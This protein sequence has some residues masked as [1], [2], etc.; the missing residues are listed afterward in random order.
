MR[1]YLFAICLF[2]SLSSQLYANNQIDSLKQLLYT[3]KIDTNKVIH[4]NNLCREYENISSHDTALL[5]G[6]TALQL[7]IK[8]K[9]PKGEAISYNNIGTIYF[10]QN[11][12]EKALKNF[13]TSLKIEIADEKGIA[14]TYNNIGLVYEAQAKYDMALE[15]YFTALK[16]QIKIG[17]KRGIASSYS[18]IGIVY[19][20]QTNY[21]MALK[22][23]FISLK[24]RKENGD[25]KGIATSYNNIGIIYGAQG[26]YDKALSA[27]FASLKIQKELC[28]KQHFPITYINIANAYVGKLKYTEAKV[29]YQNGLQIA[30]E[31]GSKQLMLDS[32]RGLFEVNEKTGDYKNAYQYY[33]H[34]TQ[35]KDSIFSKESKIQLAEMQTKF[36]T[37]KKD[38]KIKLL[39][40]ENELKSLRIIEQQK[41]LHNN[42][43]LLTA[44]VG[45]FLLIIV[46]SWL[47]ISRNRIIQ[48]EILKTQF[49][50]QQELRTK[51]IIDA[52]EKERKRIAQDLHDGIGLT[53]AS[54]KINFA[55]ITDSTA[56]I[57]EEKKYI[58]HQIVNSLD[59]ACKEV[60]NL[61]HCMMPKA[62]QEAGLLDAMDDLLERTT[63]NLNIKYT[64]EKDNIIR[65]NENIEI[66]LY[67]I[68][69]ELLNNILKHAIASEIAVYLH[70][71]K[72]QIILMV[73]DNGVGV[74]QNQNNEKKGIGLSN[75]EARVH[76]L[77]GTFSIRGSVHLGT[78]AVVRIPVK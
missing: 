6:N 61:S 38:N 68:F 71:T 21:S 66:G 65:L 22:N 41:R 18:N 70:K 47:F 44:L 1:K 10:Q 25:K 36:E 58:F 24:I 51:V 57:T 59:N 39:N 50:K 73:E 26:N 78:V 53:L 27:F 12:Y 75:I 45:F 55:N 49:L 60:R 62:L 15:N 31:V 8:L 69:Q 19:G 17:D 77:N 46:I 74:T 37:E 4:L 48:K 54:I 11:D 72:E 2:S 3:D 32:Y 23:H 29:W 63:A 30:Y 52:Q 13:L 33:Q 28:I 64:F 35:I 14:A 16:I 76:A 9:Y 56:F 5:I 42:R 34:Y 67:R 7:A 20:E 40:N 43:I